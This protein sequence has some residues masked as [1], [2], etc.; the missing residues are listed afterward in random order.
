MLLLLTF[1]SVAAAAADV[2]VLKVFDMAV[3]QLAFVSTQ[4]TA[5]L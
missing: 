1:V 3:D 5:N 4:H 2:A